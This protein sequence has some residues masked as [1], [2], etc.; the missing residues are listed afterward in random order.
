MMLFVLLFLFL[1]ILHSSRSA[2]TSTNKFTVQEE[3]GQEDTIVPGTVG[4]RVLL[5]LRKIKIIMNTS[6]TS[7]YV[8]ALHFD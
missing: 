2:L 8:K 1:L 7:T 4:I 5:W 6:R 3:A